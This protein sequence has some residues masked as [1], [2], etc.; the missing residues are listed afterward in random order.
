MIKRAVELLNH[1]GVEIREFDSDVFV[2]VHD[3]VRWGCS[4]KEYY[5]YQISWDLPPD[6]ET[7]LF[8]D[9]SFLRWTEAGLLPDFNGLSERLHNIS[10]VPATK[11]I[12]GWAG[13]PRTNILRELFI[14]TAPRSLFEVIIPVGTTGTGNGRISMEEQTKRWACMVDVPG[15]GGSMRVPLLL[16][17]GR[18]VLMI[19]RP[20]GGG[21][22]SQ[23]SKS[24]VEP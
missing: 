19:E 3:I 22:H 21:G 13:N 5:A 17:T 20:G 16:H 23:E 9:W 7:R 8:P 1:R 14:K 24:S 15:G 10:K 11:R 2:H 12:C 18:P 4:K 6:C